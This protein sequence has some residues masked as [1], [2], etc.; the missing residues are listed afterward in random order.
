MPTR[1]MQNAKCKMISVYIKIKT[2][3]GDKNEK[4]KHFYFYY[5][6]IICDGP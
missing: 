3:G 1:K 5:I 4:I 2:S 6:G